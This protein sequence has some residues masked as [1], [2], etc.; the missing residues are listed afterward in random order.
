M[1]NNFMT[2]KNTL[3]M[4]VAIGALVFAQSCTKASSDEKVS[5]TEDLYAQIQQA[6]SNQGCNS[7]ADC[8]LLAI[9][10][11]ACGGPESYMVYSKSNSD[12]A[13]LQE[14]AQSYK[15]ARQQ[16]N[17]DNQIMSTCEITPKP[18]VSC[19]RNQCV[20]STQSALIQ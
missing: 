16:Y 17:E 11:K 7:S 8:G 12:E 9:G 1:S 6:A 18:Q 20:A 13:K 14:M 15:K 19:V 10:A 5:N 4:I 2:V 3:S